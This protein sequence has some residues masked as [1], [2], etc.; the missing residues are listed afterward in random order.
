M[1]HRADTSNMLFSRLSNTVR[2]G[3]A[4]TLG[5]HVIYAIW[6]LLPLPRHIAALGDDVLETLGALIATSFCF[7]G[8]GLK[9]TGQG[10]VRYIAPFCGL[11]LLCYALQQLYII[12]PDFIHHDVP[13]PRWVADLIALFTY[14]LLLAGIWQLPRRPLSL[15]SHLRISL[16]GLMVITAILNF[17]WYFI[18]GPA[19]LVNGR[20][21]EA[22]IVS[23]AYP[24]MDLLLVVCLLLLQAGMKNLR[25]VV[26]LF[27]AGVLCVVVSDSV[28]EYLVM[29]NLTRSGTLLDIG[30]S[31]GFMPIGIAAAVAQ[32]L[33]HAVEEDE[34]ERAPALW[35]SLLPY[36]TL[37]CVAALALYTQN[38]P[39]PVLLRHGVVWCSLTLVGLVF[40][41][42]VL[43][44]LEN[45]ELNGRLEA[46]ATTDP[47]TGLVNH[48]VFH[49]RLAEEGERALQ[50]GRSLA[51]AMLD[52]D[53][54]KFFNDVYG[55]KVGDDVLRQVAHALTGCAQSCDTAAR[56]GGDEFAFLMPQSLRKTDR[57][58]LTA[59]GLQSLLA[60]QFA[61]LSYWPPSAETPIP[62]T[63]SIGVALLPG[64]T[65]S[66][67][68]VLEVADTR[69]RRSKMGET[70]RHVDFLCQEL[71]HSAT[72]FS[73]LN[74]LV[75]AVDTKDRYTRRHSE[76]VLA[77]SLQIA[78]RMGLDM[79]TC[80]TLQ[81]AALLHDVG[82]IGV[83]DAILRKP[84]KLTRE[85]YEAIQQHPMMGAVIIGA[86]P[87]FEQTLDVVRHHHE[88]WDG[89][90]YPFGLHGCATPFL[91]RLVAVA[92][93]FSA[94]TTDRPYRKGMGQEKALS[95]L[96]AGAGTQWDPE[97]VSALL[98]VYDSKAALPMAA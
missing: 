90:G 40:A 9:L 5:F 75:T 79:A 38:T 45:R 29:H 72:G 19:L 55:H 1:P 50:E 70:N 34:P 6:L 58:K 78:A 14:P 44:I 3:V 48:R 22:K 94:M 33:P 83:P 24:L 46:L 7:C 52:L 12:Y 56:F 81:I 18:V 28:F 60:E 36:A 11:G 82:K 39:G 30:W 17:S 2:L 42:Q 51:V 35:K 25:Q 89:Q 63:V 67:F 53:N 85:E 8:G 37:P 98:Q 21:L 64:D 73:M 62:L 4:F 15:S 49:K 86:V 74:A 43:A 68:E 41:R 26:W 76:D 88:R 23:S 54:F 16:D 27:S 96:E 13:V 77:Y 93:A 59:E 97:C 31:L 57:D 66:R 32:N 91:A 10:R 71:T 47:L 61:N 20:S 80:R 65:D 69:L 87:G 95:V 92:D 84:G